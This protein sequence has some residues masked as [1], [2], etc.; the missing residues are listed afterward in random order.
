MQLSVD[1]SNFFFFEISYTIFVAISSK[2]KLAM[3]S[4]CSISSLKHRSTSDT[5]D[6]IRHILSILTYYLRGDRELFS[7]FHAKTAL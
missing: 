3:T 2:Y 4:V 5:V 7:L 1:N 6:E